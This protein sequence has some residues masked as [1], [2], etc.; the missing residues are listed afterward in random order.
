MDAT[1]VQ[2]LAPGKAQGM[3]EVRDGDVLVAK[4]AME[5]AQDEAIVFDCR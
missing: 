1:L 2:L 4:P 5:P 3:I